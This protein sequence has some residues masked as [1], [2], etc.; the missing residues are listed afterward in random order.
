MRKDKILNG[1]SWLLIIIGGL[2]TLTFIIKYN[3]KNLILYSSGLA[4]GIIGK[5]IDRKKIK[6]PRGGSR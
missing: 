2:G 4:I 6:S 3:Q 1:L 5:I